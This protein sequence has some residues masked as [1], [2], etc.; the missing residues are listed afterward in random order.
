MI[1]IIAGL[2][3][4]WF[5]TK[6][7]INAALGISKRFNLSHSFVGVAILA[8]GTD[9]PEV[10]VTVKAALLQLGGTESSGIITG[11]AIGSSISQITLILGV[12]GLLLSFKMARKDLWRDGIAL[13]TSI[14]LLFAFGMDGMINRPEGLILFLM[15][16]IYYIVLVRNKSLT[17]DDNSAGKDYSN[18]ALIVLL[19]V[20]FSLLIFSSHLVVENAMKLAHKWGVAQSFVGIAI[21]G[22]GTSL[23]ELAVSVGAAIRRSAGMSVGNIIGS[24]IFDGF[25]PIGLGATI[26]TINME[27]CLLRFDLPVLFAATLLVWIFLKTKKGIS[28]PEG[29]ILIAIFLLYIALKV[30]FFEGKNAC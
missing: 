19:F 2:I 5:G 6:L 15:Y 26:S 29:F 24:N 11:N 18:T 10:F 13:L 4:L 17:T 30:F 23:P 25:I 12:A 27:R 7:I 21:I 1:L 20:G 8:V 3:G 22:L 28:K 9:L 16:L 14:V